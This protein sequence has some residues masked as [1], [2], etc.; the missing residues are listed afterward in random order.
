MN[1]HARS[2]SRIAPTMLLAVG[3]GCADQGPPGSID[4]TLS[5]SVAPL[6][7]PDM[8]DACYGLTVYN[9]TNIASF[10]AA[11]EVW[12]QPSL[13]ASDYGAN[14][15][16]R[17]TGICDA[18][19]AGATHDNAIR[20]VV[21]DI[22]TGGSFDGGG[23]ALIA[24]TDYENPCPAPSSPTEDNGCILTAPCEEN[25]DSKI[26]FNL[27]VM[28]NASLGFFDTIVRF[29][30]LFCAAKLDCLDE[31]NA[32]LTYLY[33]AGAGADGVTAVLGFACS[34]GDGIDDVFLY[35]DEIS[36]TC[37]GGPS[38][39][40]TAT[41]DPSA[42]PGNVIPTQTGAS[43][44]LFGAAVNRGEGLE[45]TVY[46]NV[47]LGLSL[48]GGVGETCTLTA[49]GTAS[50][51]ELEAGATPDHSRYPYI[52]WDVDLSTAAA[53]S[54]TRHPLNDS[55]GDVETIYTSI[56]TP[57]A[58]EFQLNAGTVDNVA[59]SV[60]AL[61][62]PFYA[63]YDQSVAGTDA[64]EAGLAEA[65]G[66]YAQG[67]PYDQQ[68][69]NQMQDILQLALQLA[70]QALQD[71]MQAKNQLDNDYQNWLLAY[72]SA[73]SELNQAQTAATTDYNVLRSEL[74]DLIQQIQ[75]LQNI[76][77]NLGGGG[78]S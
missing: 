70:Q 52:S 61:Y 2:F 42:G 35:L 45:G 5:V 68:E 67:A 21:N 1:P 75:Q 41:V 46:W 71:L 78:G 48:D 29:Q 62:A 63:S 59:F 66:L 73:T 14:G 15:G 3:A 31:E 28:R 53:L 60:A 36:V 58:F 38:G 20:L 13:C 30:D 22:Y 37:S 23:T 9:T 57:E 55:N 74:Q 51:T 26:E 7:L 54:C 27:T 39:P 25:A 12:T 40:R 4:P 24:G 11:T 32:P 17:F 19:A 56:D 47:L 77:D 6:T 44:V 49:S 33:D 43:D 18:Q 34:G 72:P 50:E 76:V 16:I 65:N 10:G 8:T 69:I 64:A